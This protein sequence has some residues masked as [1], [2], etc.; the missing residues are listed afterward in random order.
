[1]KVVIR[2]TESFKKQ[3][4]PLLK[5]FPSLHS[6]LIKLENDL[7]KDPK[8]GKPLGHK[9]YKIRLSVKSKGKGKRGGLRVITFLFIEMLHNIK[10]QKMN[11]WFYI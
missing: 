11:K 9:C 8:M 5:K 6:E 2:V 4:K 7:T 10:E 1:M 3:A